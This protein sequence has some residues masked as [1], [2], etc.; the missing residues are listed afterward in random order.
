MD[1]YFR[2]HSPGSTQG[3]NG[4]IRTFLGM[5]GLGDTGD[6][7]P[8]SSCKAKEMRVE[9]VEVRPGCNGGC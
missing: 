7:K 6:I 5:G 9:V 3:T 4:V 8:T 1:V 2:A